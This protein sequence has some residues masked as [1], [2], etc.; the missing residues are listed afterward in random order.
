LQRKSIL[1]AALLLC[2][3]SLPA[4]VAV[5]ADTVSAL[6]APVPIRV[7]RPESDLPRVLSRSDEALYRRIF[8]LEAEGAWA[9]AER[10]IGRLADPL[11]V[12]HVL[13]QRYLN[14]RS[15]RAQAGELSAWLT[16]Y[17]DLPEASQISALLR[18]K[19]RKHGRTRHY[20]A[21][22]APGDA[23]AGE[24]M[25]LVT[26]RAEPDDQTPF[27]NALQVAGEIRALLSAGAGAAAQKVL[28]SPRAQ[29]LLSDDDVA[30]L[31]GEIEQAN[32][33]GSSCDQ[34]MEDCSSSRSS[35]NAAWSAGL[36]AWRNGAYG[37]AAQQFELV[38]TRSERSPWLASAGAF[39]AARAH[40]VAQ[41]PQNVTK[42]LTAAA[43][44]PRTFYGL[45][46][47]RIVGLPMPFEW[48][49]SETDRADVAALAR[50]AGGR[51]ALAL[52]Q[53]GQ[54]ERAAAELRALASAASDNDVLH[55]VMVAADRCGA[56]HLAL[57]LE[58][59]LSPDGGYDS[60]AYPV[61]FW[62][63]DGDFTADRALIYA[64]IRQESQFNPRAV[65]PAG[66]RGVMQLMPGTARLVAQRIGDGD[67]RRWSNPETNI[68]L[69]QS[70]I[71]MLM[72]DPN[73][74]G[75]LFRF[76]AAWNAG[77]GNLERWQQGA[78]ATADPLLFIE[79]IPTRETR[80]FIERVLANLWIYRDRLGQIDP[81]L[82]ALAEGGWP[83]YVALDNN[84]VEV[85]RWGED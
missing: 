9:Q 38:A 69:G 76:A 27:L 14:V 30:A 83:T 68:K 67:S 25:P 31:G 15:Y 70:Y 60:A 3:A 73:V 4:A 16:R 81:S 72:A 51:G 5:R 35:L 12:G 55:G 82:D 34:E 75:D 59:R 8:S 2:S 58:R 49:L 7:A 20:V 79:S 62:V 37:Q 40:L 53:S 6:T 28:D 52:I 24:S 66:A 47:R 41:D 21:A 13:S 32:G 64:L 18:V 78:A 36:D 19:T 54:N 74:A 26:V 46:A 1:F 11:L 33:G 84:A 50:T 85:A 43:A 63:P 44:F 42:W 48:A 80:D 39:W 61:P 77:P 10:L 23:T 22:A 65:S 57:Q 45:L 17:R 71:E 29:R 56:A